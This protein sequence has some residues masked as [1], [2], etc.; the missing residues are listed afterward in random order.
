MTDQWTE[1]L[2][3]PQC[4]QTGTV[5]LSQTLADAVPTVN[6]VADG[7]KALHTVFGPNFLCAACQVEVDQ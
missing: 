2:R 6:R 5:S 7:F 4:R 3:C 1:Q